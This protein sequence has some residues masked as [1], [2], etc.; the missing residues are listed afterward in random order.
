MSSPF[1]T[2]PEVRGSF[3]VV[4]STHWIASAVAMGVLERGGNAFD[5]AVAGGFTL[6]IVEPHLNGP[7]GEVPILLQAAGETDPRLLCGQGVAPAAAT[8]EYYRSL[9]LALVPATGHLAAVVP[10]SFG[11][12]MTLLRDYGTLDVADVLAPAIHYARNG[13]PALPRIVD[14]IATVADILT[15]DW[16]ASGAIYLPGGS[17]PA[18]DSLLRNPSIAE[19]WERIIAGAAGGTTREARIDAAIEQYYQGFVAEAIDAHMRVP[20]RDST[21]RENAGLLTRDDMANWHPTYEQPISLDYGDFRVFKGGPWSQGPV[22][23]QQLALLK[24][25]DIAAMDPAGPEFVHTVVEA[26]KLAFADREA[27]YGDPDFVDVPL[28]RLLSQDYNNERRRLI[29]DRASFDLVPGHIDGHPG[30]IA[31]I[32][33]KGDPK[34]SGPV[35][36]AGEPT[37]ARMAD[38]KIAAATGDT[39]HID[40]IDRHGNMVAATPSGGWL[41]SSPVIRRVSAS[42]C[43]RGPRCSGWK[44]GC[45]RAWRQNKRPRSTLS[46][47]LAHRDGKPYMVWG[48]PGGDQQDQ[49][50]VVQFLRHADHGM[51]LQQAVDAPMFHSQHFP[52]SFYPREEIPRPPRRWRTGSAM[53]TINAT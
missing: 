44:R 39:C 11:A 53:P 28:D 5:A 26:A 15:D 30:R 19:T 20:V 16:P 42:A 25:V 45:R 22:F 36:G 1:T 18:V 38:E 40:V 37:M 21:G 27:F 9:D 14:A 31:A 4:A 34:A 52:S 51:N 2:R 47:S 46:P 17:V 49:W 29:G 12:W 43:R 6:Q 32:A 23:L 13:C 50:T 48:T 3:G 7:G 41:Q 35:Q 24:G 8:T 10:G 33:G